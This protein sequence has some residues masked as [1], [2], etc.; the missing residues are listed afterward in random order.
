MLGLD[1]ILVVY[2]II[3]IIYA[4]TCISILEKKTRSRLNIFIVAL[5]GIILGLAWPI[6]IIINLINIIINHRKLT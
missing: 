5:I 4:C 2:M 6:I 1:I 3:S